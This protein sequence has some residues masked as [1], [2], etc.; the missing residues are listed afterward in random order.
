MLF[1]IPSVLNTLYL[2]THNIKRE[3]TLYTIANLKLQDM[4]QEFTAFSLEN[5]EKH[6]KHE[7]SKTVKSV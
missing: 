5:E 7:K 3:N 2:H 1:A 4:K 6:L